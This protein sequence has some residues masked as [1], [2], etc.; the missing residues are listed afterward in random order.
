MFDWIL[1]YTCDGKVNCKNKFSSHYEADDHYNNNIKPTKTLLFHCLT[2]IPV[3]IFIPFWIQEKYANYHF[4]KF[5]ID[6]FLFGTNLKELTLDKF[7]SK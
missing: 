3:Y 1:C 6:Y 2:I 7:R 4:N 5:I